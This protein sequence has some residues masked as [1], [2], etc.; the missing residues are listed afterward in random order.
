MYISEN[1]DRFDL[2][3]ASMLRQFS[4]RYCLLKLKLTLKVP[5]SVAADHPNY[6]FL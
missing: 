1:T 5:V 2:N 4:N 6:F 3:N